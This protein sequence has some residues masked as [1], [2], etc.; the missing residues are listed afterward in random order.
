MTTARTTDAGN[1]AQQNRP[2]L[3]CLYC[4]A[5]SSST[6]VTAAKHSASTPERSSRRSGANCCSSSTSTTPVFSRLRAFFRLSSRRNLSEASPFALGH[7]CAPQV[8]HQLLRG[9]LCSGAGHE[10]VTLRARTHART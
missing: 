5:A 10:R 8:P 1:R 4:S 6:T 3:C 7:H 2:V 9:P